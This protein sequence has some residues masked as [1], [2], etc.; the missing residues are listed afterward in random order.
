MLPVFYKNYKNSKLATFVSATGSVFIV[1]GICLFCM[2][3]FLE[4]QEALNGS[5]AFTSGI[6]IM[7][8]C[9]LGGVLAGVIMNILAGQIAKRRSKKQRLTAG[10]R[11]HAGSGCQTDAQSQKER[12]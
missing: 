4:L 7:L 5:A 11:K 9:D 8:G 1:A 10:C 2:I 12:K 6:W 3:V